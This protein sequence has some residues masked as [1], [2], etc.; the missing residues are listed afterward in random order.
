LAGPERFELPTAGFEDQNSSAELRTEF[1]INISVKTYENLTPS[2]LHFHLSLSNG[3]CYIMV[4]D[5]YDSTYFDI[6][7]FTSI[8][9]ALRWINN[10]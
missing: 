8:N 2:G 5:I 10:L 3:V 7:Y 6:K 4:L 1:V 9:L